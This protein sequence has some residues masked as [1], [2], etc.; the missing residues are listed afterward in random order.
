MGAHLVD[1]RVDGERAGIDRVPARHHDT[2]GVHADQ[3]G[4]PHALERHAERVYP[5]QPG[6]V[7]IAIDLAAENGKCLRDLLHLHQTREIAL[8]H[9]GVLGRARTRRRCGHSS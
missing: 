4:H 8:Q 9:T 5:E 6:I 1:L 2:L 3:V 7:R